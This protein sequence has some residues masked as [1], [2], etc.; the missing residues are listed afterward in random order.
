MK[1][2]AAK[3]AGKGGRQGGKGAAQPA[4]GPSR[5]GWWLLTG[6]LLLALVFALWRYFV[7]ADPVSPVQSAAPRMAAASHV[8]ATAC[9]ECHQAEAAAWTGS[10]HAKAMQH[11]DAQTVL[12]DFDDARFSYAGTVSR[13]FRRDGRHFVETDGADGKLAGFEIKY[14]F[15]VYPLQQYL[16]EQPGGRLQALSIVWDAR[17]KEAGGQRWYHLYPG[18]NVKAGDPLHWTARSQNWNHMCA[19]CHSTEVSK[20]FDLAANRFD[21]R[22]REINVACEA[23][24]GPGSAHVAWARTAADG[25]PAADEGKG[26]ARPLRADK[27]GHWQ[28]VGDHPIARWAGA[29][30]PRQEADACFAC[31]ARRRQIVEPV[32]HDSAFLDSHAPTLLEPGAYHADGRIDGEVFEYGSF[33]Q[34]RMHR[35]GVTCSNCHDPHTLK[36]KAPDNALCG[37]CHRADVFDTP[38]HHH[39]ASA[40][41]GGRCVD[42]H[43][44]PT[45][46]MG[47]DVRRDHGFSIPN[48]QQTVRHG[49]PNAC[50]QC[51]DRRA[52]EW[53]A[54]AVK[55]W[56]GKAREPTAL[57]QALDA[58][59]KGR[60][61]AGGLLA[62]LAHDAE[63]T[64]MARAT[65][66]ALLPSYP[67]AAA[68]D[69]LYHG[70]AAQDALVRAAAARAAQMLEARARAERLV[71]LLDDPVRLVR[72]DAARSLADV[73]EALLSGAAL[74]ARRR[75]FEELVASELAA[76]ELPESHLN[77]GT[78]H[79]RSGDAAAAE[80]AFRQALTLDPRS[81]PARVNLADLYRQTGRDAEAEQ[82]LQDAIKADP[83]AAEPVHALGLLKVRQGRRDE[84]LALL[85]RAAS[86][87]PASVRYGYVYAVALHD[88]GQ[89]VE[90]IAVLQRLHRRAPAER[91][92]LQALASYEYQRGERAHALGYADKLVALDPADAALQRFREQLAR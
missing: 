91:T 68:R 57:V 3:A 79:A 55:R 60:A 38:E 32:P 42:C 5:P 86:L 36:L 62:A 87:A 28:F 82:I 88:G 47:V 22:W 46:Y 24:H 43:M 10:H 50:N 12:G 51:H 35:A 78:L 27:G 45:T 39:H 31:H 7:A 48:P 30:P 19:A 83:L 70:L 33:V 18:Q 73:P 34:S 44:P 29:A 53:A 92:V 59:R 49:T 84:A 81:V 21:T 11:A 9:A 69:S 4:V 15:G 37:Q 66:L 40:A 52:P 2:K 71:P 72:I 76:A 63:A 1:H 20:G 8:G 80:A 74:A 64:P 89:V 56:Y 85:A 58:A 16:I 54:Q 25:K 26:F 67:G 13:F 41:P 75:A 6:A 90:A 61:E 23:C 14:T 17:P 65:A 77:L